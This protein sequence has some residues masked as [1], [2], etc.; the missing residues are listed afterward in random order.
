MLLVKKKICFNCNKTAGLLALAMM[1][2]Q[3]P[4]FAIY[5]FSHYTTSYG[6]GI[7]IYISVLIFHEYF[8]DL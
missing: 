8:Y 6:Q 7:G 4:L 1:R 2:E 5:Y 3:R